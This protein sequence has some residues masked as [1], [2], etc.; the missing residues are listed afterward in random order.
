M[1]HISSFGHFQKSPISGDTNVKNINI[2]NISLSMKHM[3]PIPMIVKVKKF[4]F[5]KMVV[6]MPK[7]SFC[8]VCMWNLCNI[9][10]KSCLFSPL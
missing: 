6:I 2:T 5:F 9:T 7:L 1:G 4:K 10:N 3:I 8:F